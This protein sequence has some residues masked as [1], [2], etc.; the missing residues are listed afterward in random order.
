MELNRKHYAR[1]RLIMTSNYY[2]ELKDSIDLE[3]YSMDLIKVNSG[4][5]TWR[6][7]VELTEKGRKSLAEFVTKVKEERSPHHE[8][9]S[10]L[11]EYL[12]TTEN[13]FTYENI[14]FGINTGLGGKICVRPD[15]FSIIPTYNKKKL[16]P[17]VHE[18]KVSRSDF[19]TDI[20][21]PEKRGTYYLI[22]EKVFYVAP[23]GMLKADEIPEGFGFME[24]DKEKDKFITVIKPKKHKIEMTDE[25]FLNL[26]VKGYKINNT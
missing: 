5:T 9:G 4:G 20:K 17:I 15:V 13:R 16:L 22:A 3:L 12:K 11:A 18:I 26:I 1:L 25:Y 24:Y 19:L 8:L 6:S 21:K 10:K 23:M 14:E 7:V 2:Q